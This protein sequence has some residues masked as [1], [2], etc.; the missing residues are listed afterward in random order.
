MNALRIWNMELTGV[1]MLRAVLIV[2]IFAGSLAGMIL[3][4]RASDAR[5]VPT[6]FVCSQSTPCVTATP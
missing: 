1:E 6:P 3:Y 5:K 4:N 2:A